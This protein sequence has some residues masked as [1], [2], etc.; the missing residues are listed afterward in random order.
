MVQY[1]DL[2]GRARTDRGDKLD[3]DGDAWTGSLEF[4]YP[5]LLS[6]AWTLEPQAQLIAQKVSLKGQ[7][8]QVSK[9]DFDSDTELT[10][11]LGLRLEGDFKAQTA[12]WRPFL[13]ANIWHVD[14]GQDTVT[15]D[16]SDKIETDFKGTSLEIEA[17]LVAQL[18]SNFAVQFSLNHRRN[19]DS[20]Q[21]EGTGANA[22]VRFSF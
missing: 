12:D 10:G 19:L 17:G 18:T 3:L 2:D 9:V 8:D 6:T 15:F 11:R 1:T 13:Q 14:G 7:R 16:D 4:G 22:G 20:S 5:F 21:L